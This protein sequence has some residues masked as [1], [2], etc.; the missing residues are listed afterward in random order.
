MRSAVVRHAAAA[1]AVWLTLSTV[2]AQAQAPVGPPAAIAAAREAMSDTARGASLRVVLVTIGQGDLLWERYGHNL[3]WISDAA[4][5]ESA[6]WE[7]GIFDFDQPGF[8]RRFLFAT[9]EYKLGRDD[10]NQKLDYYARTG[11]E[12]VGQEL[13]LTSGQRAALA[14][15]VR[16]N[17][18]PGNEYYRYDY[19]LDNCSTRLRDALDFVLGGAL[20]AALEPRAG[21]LT[22]RSETLRLNQHDP[23]LFLGMD[24]ALGF[25]ADHAMNAWEAGFVP[26][27]LRDALRT[28]SVKRPDGTVVPLVTSERMLARPT[29]EAEPARIDKM[30]VPLCVLVSA[31]VLSLVVIGLGALARRGKRGAGLVVAG[32]AVAVHVALGLMAT[33][34]VFM[35]LFTRH[36]FWAWNPHVLLFTPV[37]LVV[38]GSLIRSGQRRPVRKW[39]ERYHLVMAASGFL[40]VLAVLATKLG[41]VTPSAEFLLLWANASWLVHMALGIALSKSPGDGG[42][43]DPTL[44]AP[45][46]RLA[47]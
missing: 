43:L 4:T 11:R 19:F 41:H 21:E 16:V 42:G 30:W 24:L 35:W 3:L 17:A 46:V 12:V 22:Y 38:A 40:V 5:G 2:P 20:R 33:L 9:A 7:W 27:R 28:V 34:L 8:I 39:V 14:A 23:W 32:I 36:A 26:M 31:V 6:A 29:R 47:A 45:G 18:L 37:S 44:A 10:A 1:C 15:F 13:A 25:P